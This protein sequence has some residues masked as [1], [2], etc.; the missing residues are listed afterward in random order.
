MIEGYDRSE[1]PSFHE[2]SVL[3]GGQCKTDDTRLA[4]FMSTFIQIF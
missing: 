2:I 1:A 4:T 3:C